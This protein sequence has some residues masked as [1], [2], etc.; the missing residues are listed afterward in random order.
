MRKST[1]SKLLF[2]AVVSV[3]ALQSCKDD[4]HLMTPL[5]LPDQSFTEEFDTTSAAFA[6]GWKI[7]NASTPTAYTG[8]LLW[9]QGGDINPWF[10]AYSNSGSFQGFIGS[11]AEIT[12][13]LP[14]I[15]PPLIVSNWLV[16][17]VL[18]IKNGDK[19]VFYTRTRFYTDGNDYG[20]RLQLRFSK[21]GESLNVGS[22][23]DAGLFT[24]ALIDIN[25]SYKSQIATAPDPLAYPSNWTR[26]EHTISGLNSPVSGRFGFRYYI[27]DALTNGWGIGLDQ[28]QFISKK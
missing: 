21:A 18:T 8:S 23:D 7:I 20:N 11:S 19:I 27:E 2:C 24:E 28:V 12:A 15:P 22:G 6:R 26:F 17:P 25:P 16:S 9:Q 14:A 5:P 4:S 3:V 1:F 10:R 13:A